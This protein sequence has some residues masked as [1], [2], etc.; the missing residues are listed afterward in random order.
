MA[1]DHLGIDLARL[2]GPVA[3]LF[4]RERRVTLVVRSAGAVGDGGS[5][6]P[7]TG[8]A[9]R[10]AWSSAEPPVRAG[11]GAR[12]ERLRAALEATADR[13]VQAAARFERLGMDAAAATV[14]VVEQEPRDALRKL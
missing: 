5:S 6:S 12:R 4:R 13:L 11:P 2:R 3:A 8:C 10:S 7:T 9:W 14:R 1:S